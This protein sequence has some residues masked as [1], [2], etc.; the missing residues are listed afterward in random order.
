MIFIHMPKKCQFTNLSTPNVSN[1]SNYDTCTLVLLKNIHYTP[2]NIDKTKMVDAPESRENV[3]D[4]IEID[5]NV[6]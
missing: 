2:L 5:P 1:C 4:T 3:N 6:L